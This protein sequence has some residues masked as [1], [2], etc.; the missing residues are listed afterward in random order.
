MITEVI[1]K[2]GTKVAFDIEKIKGAIM[3]ASSVTDLSDERKSGVVEQV[4]SAVLAS[5]EGK[6]VVTTRDIKE[7]VLAKLDSIEPSVSAAWRQY[8]QDNK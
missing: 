6:T 2:D 4:V 3:A 1:K 8:D 7:T 5:M